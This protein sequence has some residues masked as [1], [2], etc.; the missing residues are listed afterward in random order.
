[1]PALLS[2][3]L[4]VAAPAGALAGARPAAAR[5][6]TVAPTGTYRLNTT[7]IWA[8]QTVLLTETGLTDPDSAPGSVRRVVSWGDGVTQEIAPGARTVRHAYPR[9]GTFTVSVQLT[10]ETG[11]VAAGALAGT[12]AVRVTPTPGTFRLDRSAAWTYRVFNAQGTGWR[13]S[14]AVPLTLSMAGIPASVARVRVN[15]GGGY[16]LLYPRTTTRAVMRYYSGPADRISVSLEN[17]DGRSAERVVGTFKVTLDTVDPTL[18]INAPANANAATSWRTITGK[19]SDRGIGVRTVMVSLVQYR[20]SAFYYYTGSVWRRATSAGDASN[21]AAN[22]RASYA[23]G[24]W[25]LAVKGM[26]KG[27]LQV[28]AYAEEPGGAWSGWRYR[29]QNITR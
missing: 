4:L 24:T 28:A 10:D 22:V 6:D 8:A 12:A 16:E 3:V 14:P 23:G 20:G 15:W 2:L 27:Y 5:A 7:A 1:M 11:N 29:E 25:R 13:E 19:A 17:A 26:A 9:T 18:S 21:R